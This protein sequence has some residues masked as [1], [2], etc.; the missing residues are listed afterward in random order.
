MIDAV[1]C[2]QKYHEAL[3]AFVLDSVE[4]MFA[5]GAVYI[6]SSLVGEFNGRNTIMQAMQV[7]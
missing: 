2:L 4:H 1:A 6:F 7:Q 3:N 5:E